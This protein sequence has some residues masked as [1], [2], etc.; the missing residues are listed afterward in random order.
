MWTLMNIF[1][2]ICVDQRLTDVKK[3]ARLLINTSNTEPRKE[4]S[5][6]VGIHDTM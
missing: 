6:T 3:K 1:C 5:A 2:M 4:R